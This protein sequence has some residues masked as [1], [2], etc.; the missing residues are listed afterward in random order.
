MLEIFVCKEVD[1]HSGEF[2]VSK[3]SEEQFTKTV[4]GVAQPPKNAGQA[5]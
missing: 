2:Y 4:A 1:R 3:K 5:R